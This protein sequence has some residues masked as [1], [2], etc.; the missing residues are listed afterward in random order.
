MIDRRN[1]KP[2]RPSK[3]LSAKKY[4]PFEVLKKIGNR[5]FRVE[6]PPE[7]RIHN[8]FHVDLLD[9]YR[10]SK[11]Q[12]RKQAAPPPPEMKGDDK[13]YHVEA[14]IDS[15]KCDSGVHYLVK[16]FVYSI[17]ESTYLPYK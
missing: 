12:G 11:I 14:I 4:D 1:F 16:W 13:Y 9:L 6:L 8:V 7:M 3:K 17:D 5:A 2:K 15:E 10:P